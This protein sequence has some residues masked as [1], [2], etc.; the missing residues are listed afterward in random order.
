ML[1]ILG[2]KYY[3]NK[4]NIYR[5]ISVGGKLDQYKFVND[6]HFIRKKGGER[7]RV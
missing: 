5:Y 7:V 6:D 2:Q 1:Q 3:M 4:Y